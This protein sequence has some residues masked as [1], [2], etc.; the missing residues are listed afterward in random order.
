MGGFGMQTRQFTKPRWAWLWA[1]GLWVSVLLWPGLAAALSVD[2][3]LALR[4]AGVG[5]QVIRQ[6]VR[7]E[8]AAAR[9]GGTGRYLVRG[10]GGKETIV[11]YSSYHQGASVRPLA[12]GVP[13]ESIT[14]VSRTLGATREPLAAS[15]AGVYALHLGSFRNEAHAKARLATLKQKGVDA[16]I[17]Q[18]DIP[19]KGKWYRVL[20]GSFKGRETATA[21]GRKLQQSGALKS[22]GLMSQ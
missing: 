5:D 7:N 15:K 16:R 6:M 18:A 13:R 14:V 8:I 17:Q 10:S 12:I 19:G 22:F 2:Q 1:F 21:Q 20:S 9:Q 4:K 3:V 11:Y